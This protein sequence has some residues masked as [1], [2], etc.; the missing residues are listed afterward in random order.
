MIRSYLLLTITIIIFSGN[1]LVGKLL[2]EVPPVTMTFF[3]CLIALIILFPV[4]F[5]ELKN[6]QTLWLKEWKALLSLSVSGIIVFNVF[7]YAS[8]QFTSSTN[9]AVIETS[10]P[11]FALLLGMIFLKE[12]LTKIQVS[13]ITLS[14]VGALWVIS[15]GDWQVI[16]HFQFNIGDILVL[17]AVFAWAI[18]SLLI[19]QHS[20]IPLYGSLV[21]MLFLSL[22]ILLPFALYEWKAGIPNLLQPQLLAGLLY[23]GIFP[24]VIALIFWNIGVATIGPSRASIFLNLLPFFTVIGAVF[25]LDEPLSLNQ[26]FGGLVILFGVYLTTKER[27]KLEETSISASG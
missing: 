12:R 4:G 7:L 19:K 3:R 21:V 17:I 20:Y 25:F 23:L 10:T 11:V 2:S 5:R 14:L 24:S 15:K 1:I 26:L 16:Q 22:V 13:G 27:K 9:V 8:L 18:Y 6:N